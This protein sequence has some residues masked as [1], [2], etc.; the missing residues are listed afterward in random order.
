MAFDVVCLLQNVLGADCLGGQREHLPLFS[1]IMTMLP[2]GAKTAQVCLL[3]IKKDLVSQ[4]LGFLTCE[5][6]PV[7]NPW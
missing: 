5:S 3:L 6:Q 1:V 4:S 7:A 2:A